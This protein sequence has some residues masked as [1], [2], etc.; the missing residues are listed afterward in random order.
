M[1]GNQGGKARIYWTARDGHFRGIYPS[2]IS[3]ILADSGQKMCP[4]YVSAV[5]VIG[6]FSNGKN[7]DT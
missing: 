1:L 6:R 5:A 7:D 4:L 2:D 3:M